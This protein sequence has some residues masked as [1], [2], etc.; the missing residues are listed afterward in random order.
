MRNVDRILVG[1]PQT[2]RPIGKMW[3]GLK[4]FRIPVG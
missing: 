1:K 4:R 3:A 2:E